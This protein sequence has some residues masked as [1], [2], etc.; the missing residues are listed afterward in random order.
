MPQGG[1]TW[2]RGNFIQGFRIPV[3]RFYRYW[4]AAGGRPFYEYFK[5]FGLLGLTNVD[6]PGEAGTIMHKKGRYR[7][8]ELTAIF[9]TLS[10]HTDSDGN[11]SQFPW[12]MVEKESR[13]ILEFPLKTE[14]ERYWNNFSMKRKKGSYQ[15]NFRNHADAFKE[16]G[17]R[18]IRKK[19][20][21][22]GVFCRRKTAN[23][24]HT[25]KKCK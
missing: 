3:I 2:A 5:Q 1:R 20:S 8:V 4:S 14:K 19:R 6:L 25:S 12:S 10:D 13:R 9:G 11:D 16:C 17:G 24:P 22:G 18:R 15:K 7:L 23:V 21:G